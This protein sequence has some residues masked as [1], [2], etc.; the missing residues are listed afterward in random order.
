[1]DGVVRGAPSIPRARAGSLVLALVLAVVAVGCAKGT[2]PTQAQYA[3]MADSVCKARDDKMDDLKERY[4]ASVYES[5]LTGDESANVARPERWMRAEIIPEYQGMSAQLKGIRPPSDDA[6]YLADIYS[7]LDRLI[8]DL[9]SRPSR[10]RE[11]ISDDP[12]LRHRFES[13]GMDVCGRV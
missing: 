3:A 4:D 12:Q 9:N 13:Y 10:G 2:A 7:D 6:D 11:Y 8:V 5:A 1:M